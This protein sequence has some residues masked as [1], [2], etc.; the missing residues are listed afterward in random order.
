MARARLRFYAALAL[1]AA[2]VIG[3]AVMAFATG[4]GPRD[5]GPPAASP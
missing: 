4:E 5:A 3:L 1:F 2:W